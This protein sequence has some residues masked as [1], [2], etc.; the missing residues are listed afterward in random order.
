MTQIFIVLLI[1]SLI[2]TLECQYIFEGSEDFSI[3]LC[4]A[5]EILDRSEV[6][7][8]VIFSVQR[9]KYYEQITTNGDCEVSC[10]SKEDEKKCDFN[11]MCDSTNFNSLVDFMRNCSIKSDSELVLC[12]QIFQEFLVQIKAV[13]ENKSTEVSQKPSDDS[14]DET[15]QQDLTTA[16]NNLIGNIVF[17]WRQSFYLLLVVLALLVASCNYFHKLHFKPLHSDSIHSTN[18][19]EGTELIYFDDVSLQ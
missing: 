11:L 5:A 13:S 9:E 16:S 18:V 3:L 14:T 12:D 19:E 17:N 2:T 10:L 4:V 6:E 15:P 7:S 8:S 1:S